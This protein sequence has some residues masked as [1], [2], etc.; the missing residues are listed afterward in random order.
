MRLLPGAHS[1][2]SA[3]A[4]G[5]P[6]PE[7]SVAQAPPGHGQRLA[8]LKAAGGGAHRLDPPLL[9]PLV[10]Q[11]RGLWCVCRKCGVCWDHG[12]VQGGG[13]CR[14]RGCV[15]EVWHVRQ[16]A[17]AGVCKHG[18]GMGP[19]MHKNGAGEVGPGAARTQQRPGSMAAGRTEGWAAAV[20]HLVQAVQHLP[21]YAQLLLQPVK[22][23]L[24]GAE[25]VQPHD[26]P[27]RGVGTAAWAQT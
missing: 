14:W 20:P 25:G 3:S 8:A 12:L 7:L 26:P 16:R 17:R 5:S 1:S 4:G 24:P 2:Q 9:F 27:C 15:Q 13:A 18:A 21:R 10:L 23:L 22:V 11:V 19:H 6:P